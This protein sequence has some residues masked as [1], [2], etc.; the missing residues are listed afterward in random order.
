[1]LIQMSDPKLESSKVERTRVLVTGGA[2]FIGSHLCNRLIERGFSVRVI[3][4]L[5]KQVHG[6]D[7][8]NSP[9]R[10]SL[11]SRIEFVNGNI[12]DKALVRAQLNGVDIVIH[13][14][15]E[16]GTGQS[17][18]EIEKYITTNILGTTRLM[19]AISENDARPSRLVIASSRSIYGEGAY[20][21]GLHGMVFPGFRR[22]EEMSQCFFDLKCPDCGGKLKNI[23]TPE[24]AILSPT[25]VYAVTKLSQEQLCSTIA[26]SLDIEFVSLRL[27][28]VYGPGQSLTNP[29]TGILSI[30]SSL[31]RSNQAI[32]IFEDGEESRDFVYISDVVDAF[33]KAVTQPL[34]ENLICNIGSGESISVHHVVKTLGEMFNL[35]VQ[36]K[37]TGEFRIGDIRHSCANLE[38]ARKTLGFIPLVNFESGIREFVKWVNSIQMKEIQY[39]LSLDEL[40]VRGLL[41]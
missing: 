16:T 3:D 9:L 34:Q 14:A 5:T 39:E 40:R 13:L 1:M 7:P 26:N 2:G 23:P 18:Y 25:S 17:M 38:L 22:T 27:Q 36:S 8:N 37:I 30:F 20:S 6:N 15:S 24:N 19:E 31:I 11:D 41:K 28:N 4:N 32:N 35:N 21:C 10:K 12:L 33:L 29:Y